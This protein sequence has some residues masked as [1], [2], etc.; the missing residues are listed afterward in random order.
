M[1]G[2]NTTTKRSYV[3]L[4]GSVKQMSGV[5]CIYERI[6]LLIEEKAR[7]NRLTGFETSGK[8]KQIEADTE[9]YIGVKNI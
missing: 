6:E 1:F 7:R 8:Q 2:V 9:N 3:K 4:V 5:K